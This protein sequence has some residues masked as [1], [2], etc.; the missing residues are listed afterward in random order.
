MGLLAEKY[1][2]YTVEKGA[3]LAVNLGEHG[4]QLFNGYTPEDGL[5]QGLIKRAENIWMDYQLYG[6]GRK[7]DFKTEPGPLCGF[8]PF[9]GDCE[10]F[11]GQE[12]QELSE[13]VAVLSQLQSQAKML[14]QQI[15]AQK[16]NFLAIVDKRGA[17]RAGGRLL[18]RA[19]RSRSSIDNTRLADFL[20]GY[21]KTLADF[22]TTSSFSF[23]EIKKV[24]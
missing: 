2:D 11:S 18:R 3:I 16:R 15:S 10:R 9:I 1:P 23:L 14:D 24:A 7:N 21:G 4:M 12:I 17:F 6:M 8:C 13:S 20:R 5:Y 19:T 22:Q